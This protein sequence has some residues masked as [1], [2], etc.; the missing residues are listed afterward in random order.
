MQQQTAL[1][2]GRARLHYTILSFFNLE[3]LPEELRGKLRE[4]RM[5]D[6]E[7]LGSGGYFLALCPRNAWHTEL[8][9]CVKQ[10]QKSLFEKKKLR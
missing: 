7:L 10:F 8:C 3:L 6:D 4:A 1:E 5:S 2:K 9:D